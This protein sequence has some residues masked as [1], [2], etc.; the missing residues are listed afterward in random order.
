MKL[1]GLRAADTL[2]TMKFQTLLFARLAVALGLGHLS[3]SAVS[4]DQEHGYEHQP[5]AQARQAGPSDQ[6]MLLQDTQPQAFAPSPS[7]HYQMFPPVPPAPAYSPPTGLHPLASPM[8]LIQQARVRLKGDHHT[9]A[10]VSQELLMVQAEVANMEQSLFGNVLTFEAVQTLYAQHQ[11]VESI[12]SKLRDDIARLT[13]QVDGLG[14]QLAAAQRAY[15]VSGKKQRATESRLRGQVVQHKA[16]VESLEVE[17]AKGDD[18]EATHS[19][20]GTDHERLLNRSVHISSEG[21]SFLQALAATRMASRQ[22]AKEYS[23]L[24]ADIARLHREG[25]ACLSSVTQ[26]ER[27]VVMAQISLPKEGAAAAATAQHAEAVSQVGLQRLAAEGA[28]LR[29]EIIKTE[30]EGGSAL[31]TLQQLQAEFKTL[32]QS[33]IAEVRGIDLKMNLTRAHTSVVSKSLADNHG[34]QADDLARKHSIQV[35]LSTLQQQVSPVVYSSLHS[36]NEAYQVELHHALD[37]LGK[38]T[39]AEAL[40]AIAAQQLEAEVHAQQGAV[41]ATAAALQEARSEGQRQLQTAVSEASVD[42][43]DALEIRK[44]AAEALATKCNDK[45][46]ARKSEKEQEVEQCKD[47]KSKLSVVQAQRDAL[48]QALQA[49]QA[50]DEA[51]I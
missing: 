25:A 2:A 6:I 12:N 4:S 51:G 29:E 24:Q 21:E 50:G 31:A 28:I 46:G 20:L 3:V 15:V 8:P 33:L 42:Q 45:W 1:S 22:E 40:A 43:T 38:S 18:V 26:T 44:S 27:S 30:S 9:L 48:E 36:E 13:M 7:S 37:L 47:S 17:V 14:V 49:Q 34:V 11:E 35:R 23:R 39:N 41:T 19:A 32:E 10:N 5:M 16:M